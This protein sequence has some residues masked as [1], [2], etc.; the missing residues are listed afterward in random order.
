MRR[1]GILGGVFDPVHFGHLSIAELAKS[2][3]GLEQ[4][5][6]V[7]AGI[8]PHKQGVTTSAP[9][10]LKMLELAVKDLPYFTIWE[11]EVKKNGCA[12]TVDTISELSAEYPNAKLHFIIG[13]DNLSEILTWHYSDEI[14]NRVTLCAA[15]R[16]GYDIARPGALKNADIET[17][18]SPEWGLSST[19]LRKYLKNGISCKF[20]APDAVLAYVKENGLYGQQ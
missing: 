3:F 20:L 12:Y 4:V 17:F 5:I 7:P 14:L 18:D 15:K 13:A 11:G 2:S 8:P 9:H 19:I 10:R 16:P 1:I 6:F